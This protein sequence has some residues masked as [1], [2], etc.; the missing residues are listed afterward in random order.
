MATRVTGLSSSTMTRSRSLGIRDAHRTAACGERCRR[1]WRKKPGREAVVLRF[2]DA[3]EYLKVVRGPFAS[4]DR[5]DFHGSGVFPVEG[6]HVHVCCKVR[7]ARGQDAILEKR[8]E[9]RRFVIRLEVRKRVER[10]QAGIA[11][12]LEGTPGVTETKVLRFGI[13]ETHKKDFA[14]GRSSFTHSASYET[15]RHHRFVR[16]YCQ[17]LRAAAQT[18]DKTGG[19]KIGWP[20]R[21]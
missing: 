9:F 7:A 2:L 5:E 18:S 10:A 19:L 15:R 6:H 4:A 13:C 3:G 12:R 14:P 11:L 21:P 16:L 20:K 8:E 17:L 1:P